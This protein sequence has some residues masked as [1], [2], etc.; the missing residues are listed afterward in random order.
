MLFYWLSQTSSDGVHIARPE[1]NCS[2]T[3]FMLD[4][5]KRGLFGQIYGWPCVLGI[6]C[7]YVYVCVCVTSSYLLTSNRYRAHVLVVPCFTY[8]SSIGN[9]TATPLVNNVYFLD[10]F[11]YGWSGCFIIFVALLLCCMLFA[12]YRK[13]I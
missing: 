4:D 2:P 10:L 11:G 1:N 12:L 3:Q 8:N 5:C 6:V 7:I 13:W 9:T